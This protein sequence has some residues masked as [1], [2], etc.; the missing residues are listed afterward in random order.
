MR[1]GLADHPE[2]APGTF[3]RHFEITLDGLRC[4]AALGIRENHDRVEPERER[5]GRPLEDRARKRSDL[6]PALRALKFLASPD[7][8]VQAAAGTRRVIQDVEDELEAGFIRGELFAERADA[9]F[10]RSRH[11]LSVLP[12]MPCGDTC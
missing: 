12:I 5:R 4:D 6:P 3:V 11:S 8:P 10:R 1:E 2:H 7:P 9:E